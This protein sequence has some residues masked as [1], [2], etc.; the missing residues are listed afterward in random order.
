MCALAFGGY[1]LLIAGGLV[2]P[3]DG[4]NIWQSNTIKAERYLT[5]PESHGRILMVG[6]SLANNIRTEWVGDDV[7]SLALSGGASQTGLLIANRA[8]ATPDIALVE[9]NETLSRSVDHELVRRLFG[10][11]G[12]VRRWIPALREE[13]APVSVLVSAMKRHGR[14]SGSS[15]DSER[16]KAL[17]SPSREA[18]IKSSLK[19]QSRGL[20]RSDRADITTGARLLKEQIS[21]M[22]T[23]GVRV[24]LFDVP[25][26]PGVRATLRQRQISQLLKSTFP[27]ERYEWLPDPPRRD[28]VTSDGGHLITPDARAFGE[29]IGSQIRSASA[30]ATP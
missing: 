20:S 12:T 7:A 15:A 26:E 4:I 1:N 9:V 21:R 24:V 5:L 10:R 14:R 19:R 18:L 2:P 28:W 30:S 29:Y 25:G 23:R 16:K 17:S 22:R 13:Y 8:S 11:W 3:S 27:P 6:S